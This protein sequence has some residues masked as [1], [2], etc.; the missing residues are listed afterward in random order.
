MIIWRH[1]FEDFFDEKE[2]EEFVGAPAI[3]EHKLVLYNIV[4]LDLNWNWL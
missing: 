1:G 2:E 3:D 4:L